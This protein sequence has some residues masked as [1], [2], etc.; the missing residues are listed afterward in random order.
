MLA[1]YLLNQAYPEKSAGLFGQ[2][3]LGTA[4]L[5]AGAAEEVPGFLKFEHGIN[6]AAAATPAAWLGAPVT[7]PYNYFRG[8]G[9]TDMANKIVTERKAK[10]LAQT[11]GIAGT[12]G[13]LG[14]GAG[15]G[16]AAGYMAGH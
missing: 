6:Q 13:G 16:G 2:G 4:H 7:L 3:G 15:L 10:Q 5:L 1:N 11:L 12:V 9:L 8:K 14:I